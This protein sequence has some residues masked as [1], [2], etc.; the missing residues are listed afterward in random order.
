MTDEELLA[1]TE[2]G[3]LAALDAHFPKSEAPDVGASEA[4]IVQPP[5]KET[6]RDQRY[7]PIP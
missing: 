2:P 1:L 3:M 4:S 7:S 5:A 6:E